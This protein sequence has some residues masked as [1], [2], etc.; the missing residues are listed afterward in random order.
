MSAPDHG[1]TDHQIRIAAAQA[2]RAKT[3]LRRMHTEKVIR[4][5][6]IACLAIDVLGNIPA[7][8]V[9]TYPSVDVE[10]PLLAE[11]HPS[12]VRSRQSASLYT[13][14]CSASS[15]ASSSSTPR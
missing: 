14:V 7:R 5:M 1:K 6:A 11:L 2:R 15:S 13:S 12:A 4:D 9:I 8:R 3:L 10:G